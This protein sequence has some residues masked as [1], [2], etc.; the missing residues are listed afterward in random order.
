MLTSYKE[1]KV[2]QKAYQLCLGIYKLTR[3]FPK[4]EQYN[5]TSQIR[6]VAVAIEYKPLNPGPFEP[7]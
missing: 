2:W 3:A 4:D 5:L 1:L 7:F 6:R